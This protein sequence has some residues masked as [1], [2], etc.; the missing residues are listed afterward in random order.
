MILQPR[1]TTTTTTTA[2]TSGTRSLTEGGAVNNVKI[3]YKNLKKFNR[4]LENKKSSSINKY[5]F[6]KAIPCV[7]RGCALRSHH[8]H[9]GW[10]R[11]SASCFFFF[12]ANW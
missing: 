9:D 7:R 4:L 1:T 8:D 10:C 6:P 5:F 11:R 3:D 2:S 12:L